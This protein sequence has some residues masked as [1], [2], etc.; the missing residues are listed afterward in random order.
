MLKEY[1]QARGW[2]V[3]TGKPKADKLKDLGIEE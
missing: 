3:A 2:D 1:Y